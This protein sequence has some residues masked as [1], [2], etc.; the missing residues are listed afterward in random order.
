MLPLTFFLD[1]TFSNS[2][3]MYC[4]EAKEHARI[5]CLVRAV[6][7]KKSIMSDLNLVGSPR[8]VLGMLVL[9]CSALYFLENLFL[10]FC[11][12]CAVLNVMLPIFFI[13]CPTTS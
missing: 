5:H 11:N 10:S 9:T 6:F 7:S 13:P 1:F 12:I 8:L 2:S 4:L 3:F